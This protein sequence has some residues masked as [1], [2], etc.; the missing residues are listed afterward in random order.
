MIT[1]PNSMPTT[2]NVKGAY[3]PQSRRFT[4]CWIQ[5]NT[6]GKVNGRILILAHEVMNDKILSDLRREDKELEPKL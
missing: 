4:E 2:P 5:A 3:T 1:Q 6:A